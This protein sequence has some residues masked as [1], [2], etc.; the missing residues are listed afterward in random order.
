MRL[1]CRFL[2]LGSPLALAF[3]VVQIG[4]AEAPEKSK[5][6]ILHTSDLHGHVLPFDDVRSRPARGS[7][8]QVAT[9]ARQ[10]RDLSQNPVLVLDSGD[11]IQGTPF[12]QFIHVRWEEPSP[13]L[14]AMNWIGY[15]AM[16]IGNHEFNFGLEVLTRAVAQAEFPVLAANVISVESGESAF[17][18]YVVLDRAGVRIGVLGL[19]T[20][21]I[22]GWEMPEHY[23]G[24]Q[25]LAMDT[26]AERWVL[27]LR[28]PQHCDLVVVLVHTG[29]ERDTR[30]EEARSSS[31]ENYAWRLAQIPG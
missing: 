1:L 2:R 18:P 21:N 28:G 19:V 6:T 26:A 4:W 30:E 17:Q 29:L 10:V 22:P 15:D 5:I 20:P 16:A 9:F 8:A 25:F 12:E 23:R 24:L 11:T 14:D 7:L 31:Y 27:E 3:A 13:T